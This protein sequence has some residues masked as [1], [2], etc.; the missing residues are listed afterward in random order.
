MLV[1][2]DFQREYGLDLV[3]EVAGMTWRRFSVLLRGL[4]PAS[5]CNTRASQR[6]YARS[7][8][9]P[10]DV[11]AIEDPE[12]ARQAFSALF[13]PGVWGSKAAAPDPEA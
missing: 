6:K 11:P 7:S 1:E 8:D 4:G 13:P 9:N 5:A 10:A 12:T 3:V 2:S